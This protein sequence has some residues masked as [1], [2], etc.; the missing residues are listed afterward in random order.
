M[1]VLET[2]NPRL[3]PLNV[4]LPEVWSVREQLERPTIHRV[5]ETTDSKQATFTLAR[6]GKI[7]GMDW[8]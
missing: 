1:P 3:C 7:I 8:P 6:W 2:Q 5:I 4:Y